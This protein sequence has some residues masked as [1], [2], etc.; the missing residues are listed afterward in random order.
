MRQ[1]ELINWYLKEIESEIET[2]Q[3]LTDKKLLVEKV[4]D[5]LVHHV[6]HM[7]S[8]LRSCDLDVYCY[9]VQ[10]H[11]LLP[12][13]MEEGGAEEGSEDNPYLVVHP[14]YVIES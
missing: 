7:T 1:D 2:V 12:L 11:V 4:I 10:D 8:K 9:V 5:R 13:V 3:E 14:N 6:S